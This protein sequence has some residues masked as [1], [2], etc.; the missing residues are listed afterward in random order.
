MRSVTIPRWIRTVSF[1]YTWIIF[2]GP[3]K[4]DHDP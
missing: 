1:V 4:G 3:K 2:K